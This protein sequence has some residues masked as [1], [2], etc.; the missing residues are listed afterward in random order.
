M[1]V[2]AYYR[3]NRVISEQI[4]REAGLDVPGDRP[5][6]APTPRPE[7]WGAGTRERAQKWA[8]G[9][10]AHF[11]NR[12]LPTPTENELADWIVQNVKCGKRT[13]REVAKQVLTE[14]P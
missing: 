7:G 5:Q 14:T 13:A 10:L 3:G 2:A 1:G 4:R 8:R 6:P 12:G 9:C 11:A